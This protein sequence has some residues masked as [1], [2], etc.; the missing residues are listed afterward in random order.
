LNALQTINAFGSSVRF[1]AVPIS[2]RFADG[3]VLPNTTPS[4]NA[5]QALQ[6]P[7]YQAS[8]ANLNDTFLLIGQK[9]DSYQDKKVNL[10]YSDIETSQAKLAEIRNY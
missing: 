9:L 3:G 7:D 1:A 2:H 5:L 10:V 4:A 6:M 8:F